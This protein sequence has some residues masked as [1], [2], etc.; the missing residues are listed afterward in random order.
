MTPST[1]VLI[2]G[3]TGWVNMAKKFTIAVITDS[4]MDL[5]DVQAEVAIA[6]E[7][8]SLLILE[9]REREKLK[10]GKWVTWFKVERC[11]KQW[12]NVCHEHTIACRLRCVKCGAKRGSY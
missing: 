7:N 5:Y 9:T 2:A 6:L 3:K 1:S 12:C 10:D 4:L 8:D 11:E